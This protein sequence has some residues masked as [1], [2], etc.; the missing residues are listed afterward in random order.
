M[1]EGGVSAAF[2]LVVA[3]SNLSYGGPADPADTASTAE[4]A[5]A[6]T[7]G[8]P[9]TKE[10]FLQKMQTS[11]PYWTWM[12]SYQDPTQTQKRTC[13]STNQGGMAH[14]QLVPWRKTYGPGEWLA[15]RSQSR[16]RGTPVGMHSDRRLAP[17]STPPAGTTE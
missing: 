9:I 15:R 14:T 2:V 11:G 1:L 8:S 3:F 7:T 5:D 10:K 16:M 4:S 6:G 12:T 17:A 13:I